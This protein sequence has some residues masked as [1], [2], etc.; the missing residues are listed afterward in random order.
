MVGG[1]RWGF[2]PSEVL[3]SWKKKKEIKEASGL[4]SSSW[5]AAW[6]VGMF[7]IRLV[8]VRWDCPGPSGEPGHILQPLFKLDPPSLIEPLCPAHGSALGLDGEGRFFFFCWRGGAHHR[9]LDF[10]MK[11]EGEGLPSSSFIPAEQ[12]QANQPVSLALLL[13][14]LN[15]SSRFSLWFSSPVFLSAFA[16]AGTKIAAFL[17]FFFFFCML[18]HSNVLECFT[19]APRALKC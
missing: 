14:L 3:D 6:S 16:F 19:V 8:C 11:G 1:L 9:T 18:S 13:K 15:A 10:L 12:Q 17:L 7:L 5:N 4:D 2:C